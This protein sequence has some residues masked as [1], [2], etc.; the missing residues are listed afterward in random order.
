M[1]HNRYLPTDFSADAA[2]RLFALP[3]AGGGAAGYV[4]WRQAMPFGV[5]VAPIHLPGR[6]ERMREPPITDLRKLV[7]EI[8]N[9]VAPLT[10]RPFVLLGHS[11]GAWLAFELARELRRRGERMPCLLIAAAS[12]APH[13]PGAAEPLHQLPDAEFAAEISRRFDGIPPAVR[14]NEELLQFLLPALRADIEL[15]ETYDYVEEP[16]LATDI[17]AMGGSE[18]RAVSATAL[19]DWR[20]HTSQRYSNRLLPGGHFFLFQSAEREAY[21]PPAA[22]RLI[23]GQLKRYLVR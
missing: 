4:R 20:R 10:D 22:V 3:Y 23:A 16:P 8:S 18:D 17:F 6:E 12:P 7:A 15:L 21:V 2:L 14:A 1:P 19:A 13:R 9:A 11:L 5:D